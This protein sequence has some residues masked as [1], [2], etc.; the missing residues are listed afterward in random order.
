MD[1]PSRFYSTAQHLPG[2]RTWIERSLHMRKDGHLNP[3]RH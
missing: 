3:G 1:S 2:W